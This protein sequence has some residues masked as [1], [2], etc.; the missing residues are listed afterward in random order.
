M[1]WLMFFI[2]AGL[3]SMKTVDYARLHPKW[4]RVAKTLIGV[5]CLLVIADVFS[6]MLGHP[7]F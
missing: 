4:D 6:R 1:F 7:I 3:A 5:V 2:F